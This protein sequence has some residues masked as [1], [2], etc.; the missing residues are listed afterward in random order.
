MILDRTTPPHI[1]DAVDFEYKLPPINTKTLENTL[2]LFWLDAGVQEIVEIDWVFKAG[3]WQ[4]QKN[5][6][7]NAVAA[8]LKSGTTKRTSAQINEALEYYGAELK[9]NCTNDYAIISLFCLTKH[10]HELLPVVLEIITESEFSENELEIYKNNAIQKLSVNLRKCE[11]VAN[12][13]IDEMLFGNEYPYGRFSTKESIEALTKHDL[14]DFHKQN[15]NLANVRMFMAGKIGNS[16]V[17]AVNSI[18]GKC[19]IDKNVSEEKLFSVKPSDERSKRIINDANGIQSAIR[20]GRELMNRTHPDYSPM[21]VVNT[22]FGG[23]FGSR[24]MSNIREDKGY[25]YGIYSSL[26]PEKNAGTLVIHSETGREVAEDAIKEIYKEMDILCNQPVDD[27]ELLLVKN[28]LLGG[29]LADLDG[30]F[31]ILK[32]WRTLIQNGFTEEYFYNNIKIYKTITPENVMQLAKK[33]LR[34][35]DFYEVVVV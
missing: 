14:A 13:N 16:D 29:L 4:E 22:L 11:F 8:M 6:V 9:T 19:V 32:R 12:R 15:Y 24:L 31:S 33:Y 20:I 2:P 18:F 23:Y 35:D 1:Y 3:I 28:Y 30:P 7:A 5:S 17:D 27:E 26:T 34:K 10:L 21:V 25:T